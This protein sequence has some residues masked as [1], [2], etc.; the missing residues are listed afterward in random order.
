MSEHPPRDSIYADPL[1]QISGFSFDENVVRVFPD[2]LRRSVPG[3]NTI[4]TQSGLLAER[5]AQDRSNLYDL[6]CSLGATTFSMRQHLKHSDCRLIG[7]DNSEPMVLQCRELLK[8]SPGDT[9]VD[10][11]LGDIAEAKIE[12][13]SVVAMNFTL[14]FFSPEMRAELLQR[15]FNGMLPGGILIISEKIAF[16]D[17]RQQDLHTDMYHQFK[18]ANG[19]SDLEISQ[20][21]TALENVLIPDTLQQHKSRLREAGFSSCEVWFQCFNFVSMVALK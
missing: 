11:I 19:Y 5:Y 13:A 6:G 15:I 10:I 16:E 4:I 17:E 8:Q 18:R 2:M 20:K 3:Y 12:Q 14:Q 21:R 7:I 9:P 1:G